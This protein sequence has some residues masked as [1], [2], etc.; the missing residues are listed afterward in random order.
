MQLRIGDRGRWLLLTGLLLASCSEPKPVVSPVDTE[1]HLDSGLRLF[2]YH[3]YWMQ[4]TYDTYDETQF[5]GIFF[6]TIEVDENGQMKDLHGWPERWKGLIDW[7]DRTGTQIIPTL[8]ITQADTLIRVF[9]SPL[10]RRLLVEA[11]EKR[12]IDAGADGIH[13]D[14]EVFQPVPENVRN[15][16]T[17]FVQ[18][19]RRMLDRKHP[20]MH[21][22]VFALAFD[23]GDIMDE[24]A[25]SRVVDYMV[26]QGYDYFW[27]SG[28][29]AGPPAP[30]KGNGVNN[31]AGVLARHLSLGVPRSKILFAAPLFGYEWPTFDETP[32]SATRGV[33]RTITFAPIDTTMLP[34]LNVSARDRIRQHGLKRDSTTGSPYYAY[35]DADGW[36]QGW[37]DDMVS[38]DAK[39]A[40]VRE[41]GLGGLAF[42]PLGYDNGELTS[43]LSK[44][45]APAR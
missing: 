17:L 33:G 7:G 8:L 31:W 36:R 38:F 37:F 1:P 6:F 42:F 44:D 45:S 2:G 13:L 29:V 12:L 14:I 9:E 19:L 20:G 28:P 25:V 23:Q 32:G 4:S 24:A 26:I 18:D 11:V 3:P 21:L 30:L 27:K 41:N 40:F 22:S 35:R 15:G 39:V 34:N 5:E 10:R 16:Y 43:R